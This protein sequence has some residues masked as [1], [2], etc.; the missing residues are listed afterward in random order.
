MHPSEEYCRAVQQS[1]ESLLINLVAISL[2][3]AQISF[4]WRA[5]RGAVARA[6]FGSAPR[7][8]GHSIAGHM[9]PCGASDEGW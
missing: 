1:R 7:L 2:R 4:I 9:P 3:P 8:G 5:W 6:G